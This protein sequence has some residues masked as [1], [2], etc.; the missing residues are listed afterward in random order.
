MLFFVRGGTMNTKVLDVGL[1][2]VFL[3]KS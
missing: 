2:C 3:K 1:L